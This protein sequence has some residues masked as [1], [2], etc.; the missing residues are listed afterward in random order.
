MS[1]LAIEEL[2]VCWIV[3]ILAL[4]FR[5]IRS[6]GLGRSRRPA[7]F[8]GA[9]LLILAGLACLL[10]RIF[11]LEM[12]KPP[13]VLAAAMALAPLA[14]LLAIAAA[15]HLTGRRQLEAALREGRESV[16]SGPYRWLRCPM[17]ASLLGMA[18][19][20]ALAYASLLMT[21]VGMPL[22]MVGIEIGVYAEDRQLADR[23][24]D[25]FMEYSAHVKAYIP[26][27]R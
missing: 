14:A 10:T 7:S 11:P 9:I 5:G 12:E 6:R 22:V 16:L 4:A 25:V 3:W 15:M 18:V 13:V 2:A 26:F 19:A 21:I 23:F 1:T 24:Q 20:T 17:Y 8:M 27:L